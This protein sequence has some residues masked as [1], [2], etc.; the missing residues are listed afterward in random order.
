VHASYP[1]TSYMG[2]ELH[3]SGDPVRRPGNRGPGPCDPVGKAPHPVSGHN[4]TYREPPWFL[5]IRELE[6]GSPRFPGVAGGGERQGTGCISVGNRCS[7]GGAGVPAEPAGA[8]LPGP[9]A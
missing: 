4:D 2:H 3:T 6:T 9:A 8:P 1:V 5:G 7:R